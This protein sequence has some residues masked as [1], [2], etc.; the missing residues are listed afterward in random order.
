MAAQVVHCTTL[1]GAILTAALPG[2]LRAVPGGGMI[3]RCV[4]S[5]SCRG[6]AQLRITEGTPG[7][8]GQLGPERASFGLAR[9]GFKLSHVCLSS[10]PVEWE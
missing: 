10:L 1:Q 8:G 2:A 5:R 4:H 9:P 6:P 3:G 7:G